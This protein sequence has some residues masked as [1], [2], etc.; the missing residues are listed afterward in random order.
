MAENHRDPHPFRKAMSRRR[1]RRVAEGSV[2]AKSA[3]KELTSRRFSVPNTD[4]FRVEQARIIKVA[5][6]AARVRPEADRMVERGFLR[7]LPVSR[8]CMVQVA[9]RAEIAEAKEAHFT[10]PDSAERGLET[11]RKEKWWIPFL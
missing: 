3:R 7:T 11:V 5:V 4:R 9:A 10:V 1:A 2:Q 6:A 8:L